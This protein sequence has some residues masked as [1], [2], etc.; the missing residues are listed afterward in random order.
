M[1]VIFLLIRHRGGIL[2]MCYC[3]LAYT[4]LVIYSHYHFMPRAVEN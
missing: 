3:V 4:G 1:L 2:G